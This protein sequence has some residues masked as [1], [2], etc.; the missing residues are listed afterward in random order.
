[1][2]L[3]PQLVRRNLEDW[4]LACC[5]DCFDWKEVGLKH[6]QCPA[7]SDAVINR[8]NGRFMNRYQVFPERYYLGGY[9]RR[10]HHRR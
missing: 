4:P 5:G 9:R 2:S 7:R 3:P 8:C 1:M 10:H 6:N